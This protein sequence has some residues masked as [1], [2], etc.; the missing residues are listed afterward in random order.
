LS[1]AARRRRSA[2]SISLFPF[3]SVLNCLIGTLTL[4]IVALAV[5]QM[6]T[7]GVDVEAFEAAAATVASGT[8]ER[9][10]LRAR[11]AWAAARD[12]ERRAGALEAELERLRVELAA[13]GRELSGRSALPSE[14][15][16]QL[17]PSGS[18][19]S[20]VPHFAECRAGALRLRGA[21]R[22]SAP[23]A[24]EGLGVSAELRRFLLDATSRR[25]G[26][27]IFLIRPD[28]VATYN[29]AS[30]LASRLGVRHAKL[31]LPGQGE[32]D[33]SLL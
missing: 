32:I 12:L 26:T 11:V 21:G 18:G 30:A 8:A 7:D 15:R 9:D 27:V 6:A 28:G 23:I 5:G 3:L 20:L 25:G 2:P 14:P 13:S 22:W 29:A 33:L 17:Q 1:V 31:P 19:R 16:I 24:V 4:L 10:E